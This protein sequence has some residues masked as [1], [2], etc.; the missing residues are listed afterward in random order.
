MNTIPQNSKPS[1]SRA[2]ERQRGFVLIVAMVVLGAMALAAVALVRTVDTSTYLARNISFKRDALNR[3]EILLQVAGS[4]FLDGGVFRKKESAEASVAA[5]NFSA[6]ILPSDSRGVPN[7]ALNPGLIGGI[8]G[9]FEVSQASLPTSVTVEESN[10][11]SYILERMC[12]H[13]GA[14]KPAPD[15]AGTN[16]CLMSL[17]SSRIRA[18]PPLPSIYRTTAVVRGARNSLAITQQIIVPVLPRLE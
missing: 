4:K 18:A 3:T 12:T 14:A 2:M 5:E 13:A 10:K 7:A 11:G 9:S 1:D 15:K 16:Y 17:E 8:A 6:T